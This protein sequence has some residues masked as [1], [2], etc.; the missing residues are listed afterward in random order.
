VVSP[1]TW[2]AGCDR[3]PRPPPVRDVAGGHCRPGTGEAAVPLRALSLWSR[4]VQ[5]EG[6]GRLSG[7]ASVAGPVGEVTGQ[8]VRVHGKPSRL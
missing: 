7:K 8:R 6:W 1:V 3:S 4:G 2:V 5:S